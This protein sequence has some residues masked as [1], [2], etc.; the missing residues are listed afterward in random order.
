MTNHRAVEMKKKA[1][2]LDLKE[3][4]MITNSNLVKILRLMKKLKKRLLINL[5]I[6][7]DD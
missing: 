4:M 3:M 5:N 6:I 2:G 1:L 7:F